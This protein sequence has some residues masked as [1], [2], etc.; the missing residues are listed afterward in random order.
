VLLVST[1]AVPGGAERALANLCR[2]LPTHGVEPSAVLL[3]DGP[4]AGWLHDAGCPTVVEPAGRTRQLLRT[5]QVVGRLRRCIGELNADVV[6]SS[7]SRSHVYGGL[8]AALTRTPE[9]WWQHEIPQRSRI[10]LVAARIPAATIVC[11]S[12]A[13]ERAQRALTPRRTVVRIPPGIDVQAIARRG[14]EGTAVRRAL[15]WDSSRIVG[16]VGRLQPSKGQDTFL[17]AAAELARDDT[18]RFLVVGGDVLGWQGPYATDLERLAHELGIADRV[19]FAGHQDDAVPWF[20]ACDVVVH[21][22]DEEPF[23]LVLVEAMALAKPLVAADSGG[24]RD[25]VEPGISGLLVPPRQPE[26]LATE[27]RTVLDN[28]ALAERLGRNAGVRAKLFASERT[29]EAFATVI[30]AV[31]A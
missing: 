5:A 17:R 2:L 14:G 12:T 22:A 26:A 29:A 28:P 3:Q 11:G 31:A 21:A 7:Q 18:L 4:L 6:L 25:I 30:E 10:E 15:G 23:G 19:H 1:S 16:I 24:P 20:D 13:A 8:A 9:V 27:V